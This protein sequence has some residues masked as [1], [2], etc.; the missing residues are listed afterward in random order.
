VAL[1]GKLGTG[2]ALA[3]AG[4]VLAGCGQLS[5]LETQARILS[6][7]PCT[8]FFF[9]IYFA[10]RSADVTTAARRVIGN[11]G[12]HAQGCSGPRV[13]VVGLA[14]PQDQA[15]SALSKER[16]RHVAEALQA[17]GLPQPSFQPNPLGPNAP[18]VSVERR[19]A[20]VFIRFGR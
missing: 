9:P 18:E 17:A 3:T 1:T 10:S 5:G 11:A 19:R 14:D 16:A 6:E 2:A 13:E 7:P 20:D 4:V 12:R 15:G 8:D